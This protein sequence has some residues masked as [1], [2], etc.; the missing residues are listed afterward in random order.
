LM[1]MSG[2]FLLFIYQSFTTMFVSYLHGLRFSK[3]DLMRFLLFVPIDIIVFRMLIN[4]SFVLYGTISYFHS[5]HAWSK[6]ER[7][8]K[9]TWKGVEKA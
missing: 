7:S 1:L 5:P 6:L 9:L 2:A 8:G 3:I 4:L